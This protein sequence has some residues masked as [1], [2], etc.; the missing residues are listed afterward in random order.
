MN[1]FRLG[2]SV[3]GVA[4]VVIFAQPVYAQIS[5]E[6][7]RVEEV[8]KEITVYLRVPGDPGSGVLIKRVQGD[9]GDYIYTVLTAYHV[10][11]DVQ[12]D[13]E[14]Y[15]IV[16]KGN[17]KE[18]KYRL[19]ISSDSRRRLGNFDLAIAQ[20]ISKEKY[21]VAEI[22]DST[23]LSPNEE[24]YVAGFPKPL[25]DV[26]EI[27]LRFRKGFVDTILS[28]P[29]PLGYQLVYDNPTIAGMS[30]GAVLNRNGELV[31]I[32]GKGQ[33]TND[34]ERNLGIPTALF[35]DR[36][37]DLLASLD[38]KFQTVSEPRI[39]SPNKPIQSVPDQP[40][41]SVP[42]PVKPEIIPPEPPPDKK[43]ESTLVILEPPNQPV[44][45]EIPVPQGM[46]A[47]D[48]YKRGLRKVASGNRQGAIADYN[49]AIRIDPNYADPYYNRGMEKVLLGDKQGAIADYNEVIR[50]NPNIAEVY[51]MRGTAKYVLGDERSAIDDFNEAIRINPNYSDAYCFRG[52]AK[53]VLGNKQGGISDLDKA[54]RIKPNFA[55]A[56]HLRGL[57]KMEN[58]KRNAALA[59]FRKASELFQRQGDTKS[60]NE[61]R[62]RIRELGG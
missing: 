2:A 43:R 53:G 9:N 35:R 61:S 62:D 24:I 26:R 41:T 3:L 46:K 45:P 7:R 29:D 25:E 13:E 19:T 18:R 10:I 58:G 50:I 47:E 37:D 57:I 5:A 31:A 60:Y 44:K 34:K 54:I 39:V 17:Q 42:L 6:Q 52:I 28:Q 15:V 51:H 8:A 32:H 12:N 11:K 27:Y 56:Y 1:G 55:L 20:F 49:E 4:A 36:L 30:G 33:T 48:Y 23:K 14:A 40:K 21:E 16:G 38:R 59:D 22:G